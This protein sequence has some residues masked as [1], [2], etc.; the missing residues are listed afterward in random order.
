[1]SATH[2][3]HAGNFRNENNGNCE[4]VNP[5]AMPSQVRVLPPPPLE[6]FAVVFISFSAL[7]PTLP[8][9]VWA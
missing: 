3:R 4:T 9:K 8:L 7:A 6:N 1:M 5:L 2:L